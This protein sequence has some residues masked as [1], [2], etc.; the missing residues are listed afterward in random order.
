MIPHSPKLQQLHD[1][2]RTSPRFHEQ[3]SRFFRGE[4]YRNALLNLQSEDL[5]WL[6]DYLDSV[7]LQTSFLYRALRIGTDSRW[8]LRPCKSRISGTPA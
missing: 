3:L 1:L 7:S 5:S 8:Y 4:E 2:D 6:V